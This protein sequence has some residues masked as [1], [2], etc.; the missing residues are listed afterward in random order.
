MILKNRVNSF[1]ESRTDG[2]MIP[3]WSNFFFPNSGLK[4]VHLSGL[5][6]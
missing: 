6:K 4:K 2:W 5:N 1:L 3:G